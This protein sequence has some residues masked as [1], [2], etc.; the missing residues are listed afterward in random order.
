MPTNLC[1]AA[2]GPRKKQAATQVASML[3]ILGVRSGDFFLLCCPSLEEE[4][5]T[6]HKAA[7]WIG[8]TVASD[9]WHAW[10]I[11][12]AAGLQ[13]C[14]AS[15]DRKRKAKKQ[16]PRADPHLGAKL[17]E[18]STCLFLTQPGSLERGCRGDGTGSTGGGWVKK[19][20]LRVRI[21]QSRNHKTEPRIGPGI[22]DH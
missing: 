3:P 7:S 1:S 2:L 10:T 12:P 13:L 17:Q 5:S 11:L 15:K 22:R 16:G 18:A 4:R 14:L 6:G 19:E 21:F 8:S 20:R 9:T